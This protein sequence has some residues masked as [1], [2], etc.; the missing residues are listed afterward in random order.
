MSIKKK[1]SGSMHRLS[2]EMGVHT[3]KRHKH[4]TKPCGAPPAVP[5]NFTLSFK[6]TEG[7]TK[8]IWSY[9]MK[10]DRVTLDEQGSK[11]R[12]KRYDVERVMCDEDGIPI[13]FEDSQIRIRKNRVSPHKFVKISEL[14]NP[15]GTTYRVKTQKPHG[16]VVGDAVEIADAK[17]TAYNGE[18]VVAGVSDT[19]T[20]TV[21][22]SDTGV[23]DATHLGELL[24]NIQ[25]PKLHIIGN[26]VP[27]PRHWYE[28]AR[29]RAVDKD[30]CAGDWSPFTEPLLPY[31]TVRPPNPENVT[32]YAANDR[33]HIHST[34]PTVDIDRMGIVTASSGSSSL[35]G[36]KTHFGENVEA[37]NQIKVGGETKRVKKING[38]GSLTIVGTWSSNH[39]DVPYYLVEQDPDIYLYGFQ[40]A[41]AADVDTSATPDDWS[42]VYDHARSKKPHMDFRIPEADEDIS[43]Y[44]RVH[45]LTT[46]LTWSEWVPG[47]R[48]ANSDPDAN[49]QKIRVLRDVVEK[50]FTIPGP[51]EVGVYP[52]AWR[53][54]R[55]YRFKRIIADLEHP[56]GAPSGSSVKINVR[57]KTADLSDDD[58]VLGTDDVLDI[59]AGDF[60]DATSGV[61]LSDFAIVN[62]DKNERINIKIIQIGSGDPGRNLTVTL[63][64][65]PRDV[66]DD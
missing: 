54:P 31:S 1:P 27:H 64:L 32:V 9:K 5:E 4:R 33:L 6:S 49:G 61:D 12:I 63:V 3:K 66:Q 11:T 19:S 25:G 21:T 48:T 58:P 46:E 40:I 13:E 38:S 55:D 30:D 14:T 62:L 22:G 57:R 36:T 2:A 65:I 16:F 26:K 41:Q 59:A 45:T 53:A 15:S 60:H 17:P 47:R 29:I 23:A 44:A 34:R 51:L 20:L 18:W 43:Y 8:R 39:T 52:Q 50:T 35:S 37:G 28:K 10:W 56:D 24:D 42:D 7:E